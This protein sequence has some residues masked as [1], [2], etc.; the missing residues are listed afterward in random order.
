MRLKAT[1]FYTYYRPTPC[2]LRVYLK[3]MGVEE[4]LPSPYEE[5]ILRLGKQHEMEHLGSLG[6]VADI[7]TLPREQRTASTQSEMSN[8]TPIIYQGVLE[9]ETR[10]GSVSCQ[11]VGQPDFLI[12]ANDGRYLIRDSKISRRITE[13]DHAEILRQL[14]LYGWL[15]EQVASHPPSGIQ[16]HSGTGEIV[17]TVYDGGTMALD[18]LQHI[19]AVRQE[20][21]EPYSPVGW[22]K[23]SNCG[24]RQICWPK[25][26]KRHDVAIVEG[27]DK[28]LASALREEGV[29]TIG[30]LLAAFDEESLSELKKPHGQRTQ[31]VGKKATSI[32][33]MARAMDSGTEILIESPTIPCHDDYVMFDLEGLPPHLDETDKIYLWGMQVFGTTPCDY[34]PAVAGFGE[35]GDRQGWEDFL[36]KAAQIFIE[37]GDIPFVHWAVYEKI[38]LLKY[39]DRFDDRDGIAARVL[40]NLLDL[41]PITKKSIALPVASYSLKVIEKYVGYERTQEEYGGDWS[42]AKYIEATELEDGKK[43]DEVMEQILTY[44]KED[45][46]ATWAVLQ[47]LN[48][49]GT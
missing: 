24:Y 45:L 9:A 28:G 44:N 33:R 23:C 8:K 41:Y 3:Q 6:P 22:S 37:H 4:T 17:D 34:L 27:V 1:D 5:V 43:Q 13:K 46:A 18:V 42:M 21:S 29:T 32:L 40:M 38:H 11:I 19:V 30:E 12:L 48:E 10:L 26:E 15:Y 47:W 2:D 14:E 36:S 16:V 35:D 49:K 20:D 7:S 25:A 31:R 39:I